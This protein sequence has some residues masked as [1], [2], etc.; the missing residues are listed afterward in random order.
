[1]T[2]TNTRSSEVRENLDRETTE[3]T[4]EEQDAL[5]IPEA[6]TNRFAN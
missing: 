5:H 6:I 2:R 4:F 3:Y 1:M